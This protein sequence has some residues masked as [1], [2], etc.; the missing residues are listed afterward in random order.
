M[1][2]TKR[3][4]PAKEKVV[5][6]QAYSLSDAADLVVEFA[7]AGF[8]ESFDVSVSLGLDPKKPDQQLRRALILPHGSGKKVRVAVF[9]EGDQAEEAEKQG[10]DAVGMSDLAEEMRK[11]QCDYDVVI[12]SLQAMPLVGKL[13]P[14]LGPKGIMPNPKLGTVTANVGSAV[15]QAKSGRIQYRTDKSGM[16]NCSVGKASFAKEQ[17]LDNVRCLIDDLKKAK[18]STAKGVYLKKVVVS[19]TMG[20]GVVVEPASVT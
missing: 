12:A 15:K 6:N 2:E 5:K 13:G 11:G 8:D 20:V 9:A 7:N 17:L 19:S 3:M 16:V 10:A 4:A 18:P 14:V 1:P